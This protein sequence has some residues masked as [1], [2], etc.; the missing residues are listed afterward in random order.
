MNQPENGTIIPII[1]DGT[2]VVAITSETMS[3]WA[4]DNDAW[5]LDCQFD[6]EWMV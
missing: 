3:D 6:R 5:G 4:T 2:E 1:K